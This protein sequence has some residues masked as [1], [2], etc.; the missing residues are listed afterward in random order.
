M[1][2]ALAG[3]RIDA[4]NAETIG[5]PLKMKDAARQAANDSPKGVADS[6]LYQLME[7]YLEF[8]HTKTDV[9]RDRVQ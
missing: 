5:F 2:I 6:P 9:F 4:A 3:R 8:D 7:K 1:I